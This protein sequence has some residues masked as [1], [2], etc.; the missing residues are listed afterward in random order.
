M[1][2]N[3]IKFLVDVWFLVSVG[4]VGCFALGDLTWPDSGALPRVFVWRLAALY[5]GYFF[6]LCVWGL[7]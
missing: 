7:A 5:C 4:F 2:W 1:S 3:E 6:F